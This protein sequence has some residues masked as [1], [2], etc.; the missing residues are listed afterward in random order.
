MKSFDSAN[1]FYLIFINVDA[2]IEE[3]NEDKYLIFAS[4]SKNKEVLEKYT[5]LWDEIKSQIEKISG[6]K[7]IKYRRDFI[8]IRFELDD[9]LPLCKIL[10]IP[11]CIIVVGPVF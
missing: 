9:D 5:E 2:Y 1:S 3:S 6:N 4:T 10:S 7:N 11:A 8:K